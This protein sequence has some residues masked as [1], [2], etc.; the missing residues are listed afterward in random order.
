VVKGGENMSKELIVIED[1][2][3]DKIHS[4]RGLKVMLDRD[5]ADLYGVLTRN[6]NKAVKRNIE[7]FPKDFMFQLTENES[8]NLKF[9]FGTSSSDSLRFQNG[10]LE[11][12][13]GKHRKYLPYVFTEQGIATLSG[14]LKSKRAVEVNIQ[15]MRA[16]IAM[17][18]FIA[19]NAQIFQRLGSVEKKQLTYEIKTDKRLEQIFTAIESKEIKPEKGIFFNGQIFDAYKFVSDLVRSAKKSI[20]LIDNY[21][22]DSV[23][24][25][26]S[27]RN[28]NVK[29]T[30]FTKEISKQLYLDLKKYNSQYFPV[31]I[32]E[33]KHAHDRFMVIDDKEVYHIGA[34]L[35]DLG[36]KWFA[37]SK[38]D[39]EAFKLLKRL[40][41]K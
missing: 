35:K 3:K 28:K 26:F 16:F 2:I 41:L 24:T 14:V 23:L 36:K 33:F 11:K 4:I 21:V 15:I 18:K 27:K 5:L 37:F 38:F 22:D 7:R 30:I 19:S 39:K 40:G 34:S 25:L 17:R 32:K 12:K 9:Q 20:I 29:V 10:T 1:S 13:R 6:L 31:V 8:E